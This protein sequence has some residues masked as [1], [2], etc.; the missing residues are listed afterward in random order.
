MNYI[1]YKTTNIINGKI[2]VGV[3][4]TNPDVF[5]GYIGCGVTHKDKKENVKGFPSA[6][7][8]YGYENFKRETIEIFPDTEQG[9]L[10]AY[11]LEAKIVNEEFV[12]SSKTYNLTKG[13]VITM[14]E[15]N[16]IEIA[17]YDL[18]GNFIRTWKS[19]K[20]AQDALNLSSI[21]NA[22]CGRSKYCGDWQWKYYNGD[23]SNIEPIKR[24][25]KSVYQFDLQG[26]LLKCW[27]SASEASKQFKNPDSAKTAIGNVCNGRANQ[28]YGYYW[29]FK[30]K[31]EFQTNKHYAAVAK[32]DD[33]GNFLES[34]SSIAEAGLKNGMP[35]HNNIGAAI[36]GTQKRCGGFRWRYF[37][38]NKS[39]IEPLR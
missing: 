6:V 34:Y 10:D 18:D 12:K 24:K 27:K 15:V 28:A 4:R 9:K 29:S 38:G 31:F 11:A 17:Q 30:T 7:K 33:E 21:Y 13:G 39:N 25:E 20:Q 14:S 23:D 32:Y 3:H 19:I 1:V 26:N 22:V 36:K 35:A 5:D 16:E 37:Y 8:K 2:Y